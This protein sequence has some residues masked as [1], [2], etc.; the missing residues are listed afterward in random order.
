[1]TFLQSSRNITSYYEKISNKAKS[2]QRNAKKALTN[3]EKFC[4]EN[5]NDRSIDEVIDEINAVKSKNE[6]AVYDTL[7]SWLNWNNGKIQPSTLN[8]NFSHLKQYLYYRGIKLSTLDIKENL[9]FPKAEQEELYPLQLDDIQK[10][11]TV[12]SYDKKALYI[13]QLSSGMRIGEIVQIRKKDLD[14]DN[15]R[16][17]VKIPA[18]FTKLKK[19]RT[20]FLSSEAAQM[21][22]PKL[23]RISDQE[24]VWGVNDDY[25]KAETA[26]FMALRN[27]L[28]K[29]GLDEKYETTGRLKISTHSFRA[30]FITKLSR[31]DE[32]FAK[33]LAGQKGYLLQYDRMT[34]E[35]K[36]EKYVELES[37]LLI[38]DDSKKNAKIKKLETE[39]SSKIQELEEKLERITHKMD[40]LTRTNKS[41]YID[42]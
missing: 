18:R 15:E 28:K 11:F 1:M 25:E 39:N 17:T 42:N 10:I 27:Y 23:K 13:A 12:A 7:Q 22:K 32:N 3:F 2:S 30:Y 38:F 21:I 40:L 35:E 9:T 24:L 34:D 31:H 26:E 41:K 16:I 29:V 4:N 14:L 6:N 19:A 36:L 33:K 8:L 5:Y 20:T 37:E